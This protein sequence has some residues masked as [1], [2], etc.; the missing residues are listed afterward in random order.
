MDINPSHSHMFLS[1]T[2]IKAQ[3]DSHILS[4]KKIQQLYHSM[5]MYVVVNANLKTMTTTFS[6]IKFVTNNKQM[7]ISFL[8]TSFCSSFCFLFSYAFLSLLLLNV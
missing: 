7:F 2:H 5:C 8:V 3:Y 6:K 1:A 4:P